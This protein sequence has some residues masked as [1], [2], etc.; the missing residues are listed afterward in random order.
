[1][2][3]T[4]QIAYAVAGACFAATLSVAGAKEWWLAHPYTA[5]MLGVAMPLCVL[6]AWLSE[7]RFRGGKIRG[8]TLVSHS[9][10]AMGIAAWVGISFGA[11]ALLG[12]L[13]S[14]SSRLALGFVIGS[15]VLSLFSAV[16]EVPVKGGEN[17]SK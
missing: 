3:R 14:L 11:L 6:A 12:F 5:T 8:F 15:I 13:F 2:R 1:M 4:A 9:P 16:E 10:Q 7:F 17:E